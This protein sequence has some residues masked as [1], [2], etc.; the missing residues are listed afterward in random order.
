[1][2]LP[3]DLLEQAHHLATKEAKRPRQASLR[4]ATSAAYYALFHLLA[5]DAAHQ[6]AGPS[7]DGLRSLIQRAILHADVKAV[8]KSFIEAD[9]AFSKNRIVGKGLRLLS[10][11]LQSDLI[12]VMTVLTELQEERHKADYDMTLS[13]NRQDV[14]ALV[15]SAREAFAAWAR[16]RSTPN[17]AVFRAALFHQKNWNR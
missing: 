13:W 12:V 2:S 9:S 5:H 6:A 11:P 3:R 16:V 14:L 15:Q 7:P 1:V 17:A 4:R 8:C 10:F